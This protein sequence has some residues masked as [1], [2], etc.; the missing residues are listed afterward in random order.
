MVTCGRCG[1]EGHTRRSVLCPQLQ[2]PPLQQH[3]LSQLPPQPIPHHSV[4]YTF[5]YMAE[6]FT[7]VNAD[8]YDRVLIYSTVFENEFIYNESVQTQENDDGHVFLIKITNPETN[9]SLVVNVGGPHREYDTRS[10]YA[11]NWIFKALGFEGEPG[12]VIWEK[13]IQPPPRAT[14]ITIRPIDDMMKHIDAREEIEEHLKL[15]NVLQE[16]T[17][18]PIPLRPFDNYIAHIYIEKIEPGPVVLLRNEVELE[19]VVDEEL[20]P[21]PAPQPQP[22]PRP[23]TPIPPQTELLQLPEELPTQQPTPAERRA[24]MAAAAERR[25]LLTQESNTSN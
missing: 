3:Q 15:F 6:T 20:E 4:I 23:P 9:H 18:I 17:M 22:K 8:L 11:P 25:R 10:I 14:K 16:G 1:E 7:E 19:L 5:P 24:I 13:V 2:A 21:E 12:E